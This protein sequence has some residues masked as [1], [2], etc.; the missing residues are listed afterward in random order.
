MKMIITSLDFKSNYFFIQLGLIFFPRQKI[1]FSHSTSLCHIS[2]WYRQCSLIPH[3]H[4]VDTVS[5][6]ED[7]EPWIQDFFIKNKQNG[8]P[9]IDR[10]F[11][12]KDDSL[13]FRF[14]TN[15]RKK[16]CQ[17]KACTLARSMQGA[18]CLHVIGEI[19][20]GICTKKKKRLSDF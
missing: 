6:I 16:R 13:E 4:D 9:Y 11:G 20:F 17:S 19:K 14:E 10:V 1:S 8:G 7:F 5:W 18:Y 12:L 15:V 2:G 3:D